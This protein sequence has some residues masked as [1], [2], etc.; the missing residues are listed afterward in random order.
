MDWSALEDFRFALRA[1]F[2]STPE[3]AMAFDRVFDAYWLGVESE[4]H[5]VKMRSEFLKGD[6]EEGEREGHDD[7]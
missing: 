5:R 3:E 2:A 6:L 4:G 7:A 1:N